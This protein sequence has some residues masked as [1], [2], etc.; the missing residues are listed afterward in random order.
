MFND[1]DFILSSIRAQANG[2]YEILKHIE[3]DRLW[4]EHLLF[5][6]KKIQNIEKSL[7]KIRTYEFNSE[8]MSL[9]H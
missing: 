2:L 3:E 8:R 6:T 5:Y 4:K 1:D 7:K 9:I